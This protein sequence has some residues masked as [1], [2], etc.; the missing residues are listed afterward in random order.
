M[1]PRILIVEDEEDTSQHNEDFLLQMTAGQ[2]L[3]SGL[4]GFIIHK[5]MSRDEAFEQLKTAKKESSPYDLVLLDLRLP[6]SKKNPKQSND[7]GVEV[8]KYAYEIGAARG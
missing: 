5:A 8:L 6:I 1:I 7:H 3:A 2:K 4:E